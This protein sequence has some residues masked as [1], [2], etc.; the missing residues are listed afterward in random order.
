MLW[1]CAEDALP[2]FAAAL[3]ARNIT[4]RPLVIYRTTSVH[5]PHLATDVD[6]RVYMSPS[7]VEAALTWELAH[8]SGDTR[9]FA[10]GGATARALEAAGLAAV[11]PACDDG[12]ITEA[13][14]AELWRHVRS[15]ETIR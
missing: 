9:R 12:P 14:V 2:D 15:K 4:L 6:A 5:A 7:A 3:R 1:P 8:E 11:G 10:L 13:L